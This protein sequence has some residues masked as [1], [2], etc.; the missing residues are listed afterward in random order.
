[1]QRITR[2]GHPVLY[3]K[4]LLGLILL[5]S[6][7]AAQQFPFCIPNAGNANLRSEGL[8]ESAP[9]ITLQCSQAPP[10]VQA[11]A[12]VSIFPSVNITNHLST[13]NTPDVIVSV[14]AGGFQQPAPASI[15]L[16][17]N[18]QL[19]ISGIEYTPGSDGTVT[20][21][22]SN[23]RLNANSAAGGTSPLLS[24]RILATG[25]TLSSN[26]IQL[27]ALASGLLASQT[28]GAFYT[29]G[30]AFPVPSPVNMQSLFSAGTP[31]NTTRVTEGFANAFLSKNQDPNSDTG[32]RVIISF[33]GL[34]PS[35]QVYVP[36]LIAGS[37]A[38]QP[39]SAGDLGLGQSA[40]VY[41]SSATGSLLLARVNNPNA[42]GSGGSPF[43]KPPSG[44]TPAMTLSTAT[45]LTVNGGSAFV[46]YE[47]VDSN[48]AVQESAQIP[49]FVALAAGTTPG[50]YG[51]MSV[52]LA[53][54]STVG[55]ATMT[56]PVPR[57]VAVTPPVDC[58]VQGDCSASYYPHL[59]LNTA[60]V[61][62]QAP[63]NGASAVG[64]VPF[65][66]SGGGTMQWNASVNYQNGSGWLSISP[67]SGINNAT[68]DVHANPLNL[69][70]GTYNATITIDAG[71]MAGT[72]SVPV[73]F[74]VGQALPLITQV[75][76][77]A[78][79]NVSTL[80]PSSFASIYGTGLSGNSVTVT[81][82][83]ASANIVYNSATQINVLVPAALAG[84]TSA[85]MLVSVDGR[86]S[87]PATV[88]LASAE[89]AIFTNGVLNQDN[90]VNSVTNPAVHGTTLQIFLTGL[91]PVAGATV[92]IGNTTL[93][94]VFSG[95]A[96]GV[97]GLEQVNVMLPANLTGTAQLTVCSSG[98]SPVCSPPY[99]VTIQ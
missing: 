41:A 74:T 88:N 46:V 9:D 72:Q 28:S 18:N 27:G 61:T 22:I 43:Y 65:V 20:I 77:A 12:I 71:P 82:D 57:F 29:N 91:P 60:G 36:D 3:Q 48:P 75:S 6:S 87:A 55:V 21:R 49:S 24:A 90:S 30:S 94:S 96:P 40:G 39:T 37:S 58:T 23:L 83:G 8:A 53:P 70:A 16:I 68:V 33:S 45:A 98:T 86:N 95:Q 66:N 85:Q 10:N 64:F 25:L 14:S 4:V 51:Q 69:A 7:L 92:N 79:G 42:D 76:S 52:T 38:I 81:F 84:K 34:P 59:K 93:Q 97:P 26:Q 56:D 62:L 63:S 5:S 50:T 44:G 15:Q 2:T 19:T 11:T 47:V 78:N 99:S 31:F 1:M 35:S 54:V 67:T 80:V 13:G 73:V 32:T 17:G 89:P